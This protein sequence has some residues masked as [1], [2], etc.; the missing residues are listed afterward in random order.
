MRCETRSVNGSQQVICKCKP[1]NVICM[2]DEV[3]CKQEGRGE[4]M[5][6]GPSQICQP[7]L[8]GSEKQFNGYD[9]LL[10]W[11]G[12]VST[13][14]LK[15]VSIYYWLLQSRDI[16]FHYL[17]KN[18]LLN[19]KWYIRDRD[20]L[21]CTNCLLLASNFWK[22]IHSNGYEFSLKKEKMY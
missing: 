8:H 12:T 2:H 4:P 22:T 21:F 1:D 15:L 9:L 18:L 5:D 7:V 6:H 20:N 10:C 16:L 3:I 19:A 11:G 13:L 14:I 17:K